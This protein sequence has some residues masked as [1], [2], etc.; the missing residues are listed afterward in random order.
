MAA[1]GPTV[2]FGGTAFLSFSSDNGAQLTHTQAISVADSNHPN[3][4]LTVTFASSDPGVLPV[5]GLSYA[6]DTITLVFQQI[7][8]TEIRVTVTDDLG[9]SASIT[10]EVTLV[11]ETFECSNPAPYI[12]GG[13]SCMQTPVDP[14][15]G[16][17]SQDC[18][19]LFDGDMTTW[20]P[21]SARHIAMPDGEFTMEFSAMTVYSVNVIQYS[22]HAHGHFE[23]FAKDL[24]SNSASYGELVRFFQSG[25]VEMSGSG[26]TLPGDVDAENE[27]TCT[28]S[29]VLPLSLRRTDTIKF[30]ANV[31]SSIAINN[32]FV[33]VYRV[34]EVQLVGCE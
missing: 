20:S 23:L 13:Q 19:V 26:R 1:T 2:T 31:P 7:G 33:W 4:A 27:Q 24:D 18:S 22:Q 14:H 9:L 12:P 3:S 34:M 30:V 6:S 10:I 16:R 15:W 32:R 5:N 21:G 28:S 25:S 8:T 11:E 17:R 29:A